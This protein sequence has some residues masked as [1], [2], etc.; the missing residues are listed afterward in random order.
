MPAMV[1]RLTHGAHPSAAVVVERAALRQRRL[2][3]VHRRTKLA[4]VAEV[5]QVRAPLLLSHHHAARCVARVVVVVDL[6]LQAQQA[7]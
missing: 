4:A 6:V 1:V 2:A 7:Q 3:H 5:L